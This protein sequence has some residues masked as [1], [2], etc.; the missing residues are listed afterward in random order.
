VAGIRRK[1]YLPGMLTTTQIDS[2]FFRRLTGRLT[3]R[4]VH[5]TAK[6]FDLE[7]W[8][9][10]TKADVVTSRD[11]VLARTA[12]M[13]GMQMQ[14][15]R[16]KYL[17]PL[18]GTLSRSRIVGLSVADANRAWCILRWKAH[19]A[20][21][22]AGAAGDPGYFSTMG[23]VGIPVGPDGALV[24]PE[25]ANNASVDSIPHW[26]ALAAGAPD[27][28]GADEI[29]IG[30]VMVR[31]QMALNLEHAYRD[32]WQE[33]L[34]EPWAFAEDDQAVT[35]SPSHPVD[36]GRWRAWDWREQSLAMQG[37]ILS[38]NVERGAPD[39]AV[40]IA[41]TAGLDDGGPAAAIAPT[42]EQSAAHRSAFEIIEKS[43]VSDFLDQ[44]VGGVAGMTPRLLE[45]AVCVLQDLLDVLLP[46]E[47]DPA[48]FDVPDIDRLRCSRPRAE[49]RELLVAALGIEAALAD[50]CLSF[51]SA[52]P[53][54]ELGPLFVT[55]LWHRP[56]VASR[57]GQELML[58]AGPLM[59]GSPVRRA[60]RWLQSGG[61]ADLSR[62]NNGLR[63]EAEYR[64]RLD[65]AIRG[66]G[67]LAAASS[68]VASIA[69][70]QAEEEIDLLFR[71][72][73]TVVVG[74]VKCLLAPS[75][76]IERY[77][78][79]RKLEEAGG[80]A[81][82]KAEWLAANPDEAAT[83]VG[84]GEADLKVMP[85][86]V[87]NQSNGVEWSYG[88]SVVTD[89]RFLELFLSAGSYSA[90]AALFAEEGREPVVFSRELYADAAEAEAALP[91]IFKAIPGMD[92]FR[93]SIIWDETVIPLCDGRKLRMGHPSMD[94]AAYVAK[95]PDAGDLPPV[96]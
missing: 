23:Q 34:W 75:E 30:S 11:E 50:A 38:R 15:L 33:V 19:Q 32:V 12:A 22:A 47:V 73:S 77:D 44:D 25:D 2:V 72:G 65:A 29:D 18:F 95:M 48:T 87:V 61:S 40:P 27:E 51:L 43:Y 66:N 84:T 46:R 36:M 60:E 55:G 83:R 8:I 1:C 20:M 63:F 35:L 49:L 14:V 5:P 85:L 10:V 88:G 31:A 91:E 64:A 57:D 7:T 28:D 41:R 4:L 78:Y 70:G 93:D 80:Q 94:L 56:L 79:V 17:A 39:L 45:G 54:G 59:W 71:I 76:P 9:E 92:P 74:E 82:R 81:A 53:F 13:I 24:N 96:G 62:T 42:A 26:F 58:V 89:T 3:P 68:G 90:A 21:A 16:G 86:V 52:D 69:A 6:A 37:P 67:I